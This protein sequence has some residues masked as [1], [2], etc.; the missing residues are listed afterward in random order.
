MRD[1]DFN[2]INLNLNRKEPKIIVSR[3]SPQEEKALQIIN[4][5]KDK[6]IQFKPTTDAHIQLC[7]NIKVIIHRYD[8]MKSL[9]SYLVRDLL[10]LYENA[11]FYGL[12]EKSDSAKLADYQHTINERNAEIA[13]LKKRLARYEGQDKPNDTFTSE[14]QEE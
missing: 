10:Q 3:K 14:V 9:P 11:E 2:S 1:I 13:N 7:T 4:D 5:I 12:I 6:K 8:R